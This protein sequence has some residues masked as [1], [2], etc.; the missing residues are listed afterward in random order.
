[1]EQSDVM[2]KVQTGEFDV[3]KLDNGSYYI[4]QTYKD[5]AGKM[6]RT[7]YG[8]QVNYFETP[9]KDTL[10]AKMFDS[11]YKGNWKNNEM[12]GQG[13]LLLS[14]NE[15]YEGDFSKGMAF[16][17]GTYKF[18]NGD[19]YEGDFRN[20]EMN[21]KGT[22]FQSSGEILEGNFVNGK[23]LESG[24]LVDPSQT[25]DERQDVVTRAMEK[26]LGIVSAKN[27]TQSPIF[28]E[29]TI[30]V[31]SDRHQFTS[32]ILENYS[33]KNLIY[34]LRDKKNTNNLSDL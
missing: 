19:F 13:T 32:F 8:I 27:P 20:F 12:D 25:P 18:S 7:G 14:N 1:M 5:Q 31:I 22:Y 33:K 24:A 17:T 23:L 4:G 6:Q 16:G 29:E 34:L 10:A 15:K 30:Q 2:A 9:D 11:A 28:L 3:I 21:G 26:K